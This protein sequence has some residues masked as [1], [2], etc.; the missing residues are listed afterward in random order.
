MEFFSLLEAQGVRQIKFEEPFEQVQDSLDIIDTVIASLH[1][2]YDDLLAKI[3]TNIKRLD[4]HP[5]IVRLQALLADQS[6]RMSFKESLSQLQPDEKL[7][8]LMEERNALVK[9]V[10]ELEMLHLVDH[11][12]DQFEGAIKDANILNADQSFRRL[13]QQLTLRSE[14]QNEKFAALKRN[15]TDLVKNQLKK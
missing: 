9:K 2:K 14:K 5:D 11:E 10:K 12:L 1:A 4:M 13:D 3:D 8:K 15:Y 6:K 7:M